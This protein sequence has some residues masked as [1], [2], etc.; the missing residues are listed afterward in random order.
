[1]FDLVVF[2]RELQGGLTDGRRPM[3]NGRHGMAVRYAASN[4]RDTH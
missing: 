3:L 4:G 2:V 1:M